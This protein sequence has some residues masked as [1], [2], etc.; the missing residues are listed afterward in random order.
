MPNSFVNTCG[1]R[2]AATL[3]SVPV[4]DPATLEVV[5]N[6]P[7]SS[8]EQLN[9]AVLAARATMKSAWA[10]DAALRREAIGKCADQL[11]SNEEELAKLLSREQGKPL[12]AARR[13][14]ETG[15]RL[16]RYFSTLIEA[17]KVI[18]QNEDG[19]IRAIR[20]PI[21]A[22]GLIVPWNFPVTILM[23]KLGPA[24]WAGNSV[25]VK[26]APS[27]PLTTL[28][29]AQLFAQVLPPGIVNTVTGN[30]DIGQALVKHDGLGKISFTGS[31]PTGRR[32]M[33]TAAES[34]K[35]LTLELGGNDAAIVLQDA[36][37]AMIAPRLFANAFGNA[38]QLCCAIK[39]LYVHRRVHDEVVERM[40]AIAAGW[41]VG[42][43]LLP[44]TQMGPLH[45]A[46][47]RDHV[48]D[49][50]ADAK[51][52]GGRVHTGGEAIDEWPGHFL[53][54]AIV[55]GLADDSRL[56][57]EEQF[58]PA[59]PIL[60][61]DDVDEAVARA[62]ASPYGLGGSVWSGDPDVAA[63]VASRLE[64][65]NLYVNQHAVPPDPEIPFGGS[66]ASGFGYEL[67]EWGADDFS[68]RKVLNVPR[69]VLA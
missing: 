48:R 33:A 10:N 41:R 14:I 47:Q 56:V 17:D 8:L 22:V 35:R 34:L 4:F 6:V 38:G 24:L 43:G 12:M 61:F 67:G 50:L 13:E 31:S 36:D 52:R 54:P 18:R 55:S 39:R 30:G 29:I 28:R 51:Q 23:M 45:T 40:T 65:V 25:V 60:A 1:G 15:H 7:N 64:A 21:G 69:G 5:A 20:A 9:E 19:L 2:A 27:T 57:A 46:T 42:H 3:D 62:N 68:V 49:L 26:P 44:D 66:K 53:R 59:L 32:V 11:L 16:L 63:Q 37:P 58:G